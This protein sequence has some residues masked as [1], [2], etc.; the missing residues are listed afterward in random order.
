MQRA[1]R[2]SATDRSLAGVC[3][4]IAEYFGMSSLGV[5]LLFLFLPGNV[6]IYIILANSMQDAPRYL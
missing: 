1:L 3:G 5:R 4:G 6:F 2:K